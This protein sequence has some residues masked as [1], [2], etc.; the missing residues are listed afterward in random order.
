[1]V[2]PRQMLPFDCAQDKHWIQ[3]DKFTAS[4]PIYD[5]LQGHH[6]STCSLAIPHMP[7]TMPATSL[8]RMPRL[9]DICSN[10]LKSCTDLRVSG[11]VVKE[12]MLAYNVVHF[13][14]LF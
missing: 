11:K 3:H 4:G 13:A 12:C 14:V 9:Y 7:I 1:M 10:L 6:T 8:P 2:P 5:E